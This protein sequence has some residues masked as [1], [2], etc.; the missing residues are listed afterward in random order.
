MKCLT[1]PRPLL[2]LGVL[3]RSTPVAATLALWV[4]IE[5][6]SST[7]NKQRTGTFWLQT[8]GVIMNRAQVLE[9]LYLGRPV[10]AEAKPDLAGRRIF[11]E[12]RPVVSS[13]DAYTQSSDGHSEPLL[14][15]R[16]PNI[17]VIE[18]YR[19]RYCSLNQGWENYPNDWDHY[20]H[21]QRCYEY[22]SV[23]DLELALNKDFGLA[24]SSFQ[25]PGNTESP[26]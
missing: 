11:I 20:E 6:I 2:W 14:M 16:A 19:V 10:E 21:E 4:R 3:L 5:S 1:R 8:L 7:N 23:E 18:G 9:R 17:N 24:L 22:S 12:M 15:R 25:V 26:L 13:R